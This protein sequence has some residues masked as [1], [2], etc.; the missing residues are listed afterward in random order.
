MPQSGIVELFTK[1]SWY[2]Y[3]RLSIEPIAKL[4]I[5]WEL[6]PRKRQ[7]LRQHRGTIDTYGQYDAKPLRISIFRTQSRGRLD[8]HAYAV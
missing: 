2:Q 4:K 7:S 8:N 5:R 6:T 3:I 1:P